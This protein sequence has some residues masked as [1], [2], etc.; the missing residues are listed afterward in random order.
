MRICLVV[1]ALGVGGVD[2]Q[3]IALAEAFFERGHTVKII[4]LID[5]PTNK[6]KYS[7]I[8]IIWL[9][10][11]KR[12]PF[13]IIKGFMKYA[14]LMLRY[15]PDVIHA[16]TLVATVVVLIWSLLLKHRHL[17]LTLHTTIF[18]KD[19]FSLIF[20]YLNSRANYITFVCDAALNNHVK[21]GILN[22][23]RG[24]VVYNGIKI[25]EFADLNELT[26]TTDV[27]GT[28]ENRIKF[29]AVG[30]LCYEKDYLNMVNGFKLLDEKFKNWEL[31]IIGDGILK[32]E[33]TREIRSSGLSE[34]ISL[35]GLQKNVHSYMSASDIFV[36]SSRSEGLPL[37]IAEAMLS[38]CFIV[39]TDVGGIKEM[40]GTDAFLCEA[41]NHRA[42]G[43]L[44]WEA[45]SVPIQT[46]IDVG[47]RFRKRAVN[48]FDLE[49]IVDQWLKLYT[50]QPKARK[51]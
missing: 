19:I 39:S 47:E 10:L 28:D 46:R 32:D 50:N 27:S 36:L 37:V 1:T 45:V 35:L 29:L 21:E 33:I 15:R 38:K 34:K 18:N 25:D 7:E 2:N 49:V 26:L 22:A 13:S 4:S 5:N 3:V 8:D 41:E 40:L 43:E 20:K 44:L 14:N 11:N 48:L 42:M 9:R 31:S 30:R 24:I 23:G 17:I 16:H 51:L 12:K 6:T